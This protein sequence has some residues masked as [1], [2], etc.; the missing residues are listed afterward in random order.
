MRNINNKIFSSFEGFFET[1]KDWKT[2][3][4]MLVF[5]NGCFDILHRGHID[6]LVRSAE[7]GDKLIIGLNTDDSVKRLK[8]ANRPFN[9]QDS[10]AIML[11]ALEMVDAIIF[12][13]EETPYDLIGKILPNILV[14][15]NDYKINEIAGNDIVR[16]HGG[17]V[18]TI[19]LTKGFSTSSLIK[20]IKNQ[21]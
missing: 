18:K 8:G 2:Q 15:G 13:D 3:N 9:K 16:S 17:Q 10:R 7:F 20:K 1:L 11:A 12:F 14:K 4:K 6:Y 21:G 19:P 5:T